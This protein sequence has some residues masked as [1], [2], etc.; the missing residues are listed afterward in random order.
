MDGVLSELQSINLK[1]RHRRVQDGEIA[2]PMSVYLGFV[3]PDSVKGREVLWVEGQN[4]GKLIAHETGI[5]NLMNYYL[6]PTGYLAM[7]G[8]RYPI[9]EIGIEKLTLQLIDAA[10]RDREHGECEVQTHKNVKVGD[11]VCDRIEVVHPI[12]RDH[13]DYHRARVYFS[14]DLNMPIRYAAWS[15]PLKPGGEPVL[16]EEYTYRNVRVNVG[17]DDRDFDIENPNYGF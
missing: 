15:W 3:G 13:F 9:T 5:R 4:G 1:V 17:L 11:H 10:T 14:R 12:R 16:E 2:V 6:D 8:Q 7:R